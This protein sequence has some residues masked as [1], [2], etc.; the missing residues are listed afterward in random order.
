LLNNSR[1]GTTDARAK[2]KS[3]WK[4]H[5]PVIDKCTNDDTTFVKPKAI[6]VIESAY[7]GKRK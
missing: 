7:H 1:L 4:E 6:K 2:K 3:N 5:Y